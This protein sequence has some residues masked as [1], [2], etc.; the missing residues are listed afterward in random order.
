M[1]LVIQTVRNQ[2]DISIDLVDD[3]VLYKYTIPNTDENIFASERTN[4]IGYTR[5]KNVCRGG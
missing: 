4:T 5:Q 3:L 1:E 2:L